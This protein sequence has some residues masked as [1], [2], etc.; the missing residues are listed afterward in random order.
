MNTIVAEYQY[1]ADKTDYLSLQQ[2]VN[3]IV[4]DL[5]IHWNSLLIILPNCSN[6]DIYCIDPSRQAFQDGL[7]HK[8]L[9]G[10][11]RIGNSLLSQLSC[12][13]IS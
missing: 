6:M 9:L 12:R 4:G 7:K 10:Q 11:I 2:M 3:C 8:M 13:L 5:V 1:G